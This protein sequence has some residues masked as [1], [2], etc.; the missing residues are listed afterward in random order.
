MLHKIV[1][2][3]RGKKPLAVWGWWQGKNLGDN[4]IRSVLFSHFPHAEFIPTTIFDFSKYQFVIVGGGGLFIR[5]LPEQLRGAIQTRYGVLGIGA[6]FE[7]SDGFVNDF[8]VGAEFFYARDQ[9][10]LDCMHL[11]A[12]EPKHD[13]TFLSPLTPQN[14]ESQKPLKAYFVW[15]EPEELLHYDDFIRYIGPVVAKDE[16]L[17]R[18]RPHYPEIVTDDFQTTAS[19]L[20]NDVDSASLIVSARF[21]GVVAAIQKGI[22]CVAIDLCPK[23]RALMRSL[24]LEEY[25]LKV[26]E[27]NRIRSVLS[28]IS[29][30]K[31]SIRHAQREYT[32]RATREMAIVL[33]DV[34]SIINRSYY[35]K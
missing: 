32:Q 1:A 10:S 12:L 31:D 11:D 18:I 17:E 22:P 2:A 6:E 25:C 26:G 20:S 27:V 14:I 13:L 5:T 30:N 28:L 8:A 23:T 33:E 16:W 35:G 29:T 24:K 21:H 3:L 4:W 15:R 9:Y 7:H 34:K 19:A